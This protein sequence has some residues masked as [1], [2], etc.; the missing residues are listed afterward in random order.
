MSFKLRTSYRIRTNEDV[1]VRLEKDLSGDGYFL[2]SVI[3]DSL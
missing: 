2:S 3:S 1:I